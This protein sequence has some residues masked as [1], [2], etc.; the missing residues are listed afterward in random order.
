MPL[1]HVCVW[2][3][4]CKGWKRIT[5]NE[6]VKKTY[7]TVSAR[8]GLFMCE[9]CGQF[10]SLTYGDIRT[11]Y[12]KHS[13]EEHNKDCEDRTFSNGGYYSH[14]RFDLEKKGLPVRLNLNGNKISFEIGFTKIPDDL[15]NQINNKNINIVGVN[16]AEKTYI[17]STERLD[18]N[19]VTYLNVGGVPSNEYLINVDGIIEINKYWPKR[20]KGVS[21][22]MVFDCKT[23]VGLPFDAD[24]KVNKEY[25]V[26]TKNF[27]KP[28]SNHVICKIE[29]DGLHGRIYKVK[30]LDFSEESAK[31]FLNL[32]C[33]LTENPI[34]FI[35]L[36]PLTITSPYLIYHKD[37]SIYGVVMGNADIASFPH[38]I[39]AEVKFDN[40]KLIKINCNDRQQLLSFGRTINILDYTYLWESPLE[41]NEPTYDSVVLDENNNVIESKTHRK[42]TYISYFAKYDGTFEIEK[43]GLKIDVLPV[44]NN[45]N[46]VYRNFEN[47]KIYKLYMGCDLV[48]EYKPKIKVKT[49]KMSDE[50]LLCLL[51]NS[52][53]HRIPVN[54]SFGSIF[55]KLDGYPLSKIW[56]RKQ[57]KSGYLNEKCIA[58][59]NKIIS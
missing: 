26:F 41:F 51:K 56:L 19:A 49:S 24:V 54:H 46:F 11:P 44:H 2:D 35:P 36:W 42:L 16:Y 59:I 18:R 13:K 1:T 22:N 3:S 57:I 29:I 47:N 14:F 27:L 15:F 45:T 52:P 37:K 7:G 28:I 39:I 25:Y 5:I 6:A 32:H 55:N 34:S 33:R 30:A 53:G 48:W 20:I 8:S 10:V 4:S 38:S 50:E 43:N 12:F 58:I 17:Y 31:F 23:R 40:S 9:L 21:N